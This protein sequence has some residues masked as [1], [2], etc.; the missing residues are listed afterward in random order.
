MS[1]YL[2]SFVYLTDVIGLMIIL[3]F[4]I[5]LFMVLHIFSGWIF[6]IL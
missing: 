3:N 4:H 2:H 6:T 1:N 5:I